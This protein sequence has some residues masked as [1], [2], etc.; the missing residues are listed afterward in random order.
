V[1]WGDS[2][3]SLRVIVKIK[4]DK[5]RRIIST[6][7]GILW[8][9]PFFFVLLKKN[10]WS[11]WENKFKSLHYFPSNGREFYFSEYITTI[12][13]KGFLDF[14]EVIHLKTVHIALTQTKGP[15][16]FKRQ[17]YCPFYVRGSDST[18]T[19]VHL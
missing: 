8:K 11:H 18:E 1:K 9:Q 12:F 15:D 17:I 16:F 3:L 10:R 19:L 7:P 5:P 6:V 13:W 14:S 4:G 2:Y